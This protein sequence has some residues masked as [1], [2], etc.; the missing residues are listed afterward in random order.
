MSR[1][2]QHTVTS[3]AGVSGVTEHDG[4]PGCVGVPPQWKGSAVRGEQYLGFS[5]FSVIVVV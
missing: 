2:S 4:Q 3:S 1:H 5:V